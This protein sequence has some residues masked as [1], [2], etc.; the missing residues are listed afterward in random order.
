MSLEALANNIYICLYIYTY[1]IPLFSY[2]Q[3]K[4]TLM[5]HNSF[6]TSRYYLDTFGLGVMQSLDGS[7]LSIQ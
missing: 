7:A 5:Y 6:V 2:E 4:Y 1:I 3:E